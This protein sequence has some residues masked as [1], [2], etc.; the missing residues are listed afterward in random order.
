MDDSDWSYY[1]YSV[2]QYSPQGGKKLSVEEESLARD[3]A[4]RV[5]Q[6]IEKY[7]LAGRFLQETAKINSIHR[8]AVTLN[9]TPTI[10]NGKYLVELQTA[11]AAEGIEST[12]KRQTDVVFARR[13]LEIEIKLNDPRKR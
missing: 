4:K 2:A 3:F 1:R 11:L 8:T 7:G 6:K 12:I 5:R 13:Y 9:L 10:G